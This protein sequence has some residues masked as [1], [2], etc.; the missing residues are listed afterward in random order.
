[1]TDPTDHDSDDDGFS[2]GLEVVAGSNPLDDANYPYPGLGVCVL[3]DPTDAGVGDPLNLTLFVDGVETVI[4]HMNIWGVDMWDWEDTPAVIPALSADMLDAE[5]WHI[6]YGEDWEPYDYDQGAFPPD[7]TFADA[8]AAG[9]FGDGTCESLVDSDGDGLADCVETNT[10]DQYGCV[11]L[12]YRHGH[13]SEQ[14]R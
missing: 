8:I 5:G 2:D 7:G 9:G 14:S 1:V 6:E 12:A 3:L 10:G 13:R 11:R 4:R